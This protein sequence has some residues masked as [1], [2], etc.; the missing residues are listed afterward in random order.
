MNESRYEV[1]IEIAVPTALF[2]RPDTG[3]APV[4]YPAPTYSAA[5]GIFEAILRLKSV[6][7]RPTKVEICAPVVYHGYTTNYGGP[8]RK[9]ANIKE[10][11][12]YQLIATVLINV[13]YR[14]YARTEDVTAG[15]YKR[16][17]M[18]PSNPCHEYQERF[19][20]RLDRSQCHEIPC[21]GWREFVPSYVGRFRDATCVK[22][23]INI[24]IPSMLH[25][26]W[27][28]PMNGKYDPVFRQD[29]QITK[30]RL[31][32]AE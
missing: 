16:D 13:C 19:F 27:D 24:E 2:T 12:S 5:K 23:D 11:N 18:P 4:S 3:A 15:A 29:C 32:Y 14:I 8:L 28:K 17:G 1:S 6:E 25:T 22:E 31:L 9:P 21:L 20:E 10:G 30:G 26:V 7:V